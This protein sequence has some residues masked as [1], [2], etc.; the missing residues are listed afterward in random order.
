M[1]DGLSGGT[2]LVS[3]GG[4]GIGRETCLMLAA[5]GARVAVQ[6]ISAEAAQAVAAEIAAAGGRA[7]AQ[8]L[9]VRDETAQHDAARQAE[10]MLGP[11]AGAVASAGT[12][13]SARAEDL[14]ARA[15]ADVLAVNVTG[16]FLT[17]QAAARQML[18]RG[19]GAIVIIGSTAGF[20][21]F[22][23]HLHYTVS[24]AAVNGLVQGLA[25]EW[26]Y[27]G[28]RVNGV[29]PNAV[30]TPMMQAGLPE[31]FRRVVTDRTPQG[32]FAEAHEI[33]GAI[34]FLLSPASSYVNGTMLPADG[35][36]L[37]GVYVARSGRDLGS[38]RLLA[39]G[40]YSET[41]TA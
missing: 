1:A 17:A 28:L 19:A 25:G 8:T 23:G 36:L 13:G 22:P 4:S 11:I 38:A 9:D 41:D 30:N 16:A 12:G 21:A 33:A 34:L 35:G 5:R 31:G 26:G 7:L 2:F 15:M 29:A 20:G 40:A 37:A 32:R 18:D 27:R 10:E 3:G 14:P 24:K 39:E 6:D